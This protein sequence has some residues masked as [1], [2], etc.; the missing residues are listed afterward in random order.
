MLSLKWSVSSEGDNFDS[1]FNTTNA[2]NESYWSASY[3]KKGFSNCFNQFLYGL[4]SWHR[5]PTGSSLAQLCIYDSL[6]SPELQHGE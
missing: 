1:E 5:E 2:V 4:F 6:T 3:L